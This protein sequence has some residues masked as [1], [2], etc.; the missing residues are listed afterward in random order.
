MTNLSTKERHQL[1]QGSKQM[2]GL[3]ELTLNNCRISTDTTYGGVKWRAYI[4]QN[5]KV[6]KKASPNLKYTYHRI[7]DDCIVMTS[8]DSIPSGYV[9]FDVEEESE[10]WEARVRADNVPRTRHDFISM[11][12]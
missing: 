6:V 7:I 3:H 2:T 8:N 4:L 9:K 12:N 5:L 11:M 10:K 1:T